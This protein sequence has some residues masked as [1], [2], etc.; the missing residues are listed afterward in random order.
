VIPTSPHHPQT[1]GKIERYHRSVKERVLLVVHTTPWDLAEQ[2]KTF[3]GYYHSRRYHK[4]L[5]NVT[6]DDV[7]FG[8]KEAILEARKTLKER[9]LA[10]RKVVNL[11]TRPNL[12]V[13][14]VLKT[15]MAVPPE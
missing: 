14:N 6:P 9:T 11:Q 3:V 13:P 4:A 2:M 10:R 1:N 15:Y 8:R 7:Y 5:D 12:S